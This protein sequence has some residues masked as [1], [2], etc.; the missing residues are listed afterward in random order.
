MHFARL[1]DEDRAAQVALARRRDAHRELRRQLEALLVRDDAEDV[2][3]LL[4][5]GRGDAQAHAA[6]ADRRDHLRGVD[7]AQEQTAR[8]DVLLHR[9]TQRVLRRLAQPLD[10]VEHD[11]LEVGGR[12]RAGLG[13]RADHWRGLRNL[14]DHLLHHLAVADAR[15]RRVELNVMRRRDEGELDGRG[16]AELERALLRA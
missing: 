2:A 10:L 9:S 1:K 3:D 16:R 6:R 12:G 4:V 14:L 15:V 13:R 7:A 11:D 8:A 5:R